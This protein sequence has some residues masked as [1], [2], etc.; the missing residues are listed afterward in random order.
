MIN[1]KRPATFENP[2]LNCS[3][4]T[5]HYSAN[6][7]QLLTPYNVPAKSDILMPISSNEFVITLPG[8]TSNNSNH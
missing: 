6:S 3:Q 2:K 8:N 1:T 4:V 5:D 7:P